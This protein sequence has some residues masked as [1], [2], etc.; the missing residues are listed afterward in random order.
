[1]KAKQPRKFKMFAA[2]DRRGNPLWGT[3]ATTP[4]EAQA[5][6]DRYNPD[7]TEQGMGEIIAKVSILISPVN[8][9]S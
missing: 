4:E 7:P 9:T 8:E 1:V 5:H 3:L 2:L 6:H